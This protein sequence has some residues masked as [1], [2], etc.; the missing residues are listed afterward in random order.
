MR[1]R[2]IYSL[3]L[4]ILLSINISGCSTSRN[5]TPPLDIRESA[6]V[7]LRDPF[8]AAWTQSVRAIGESFFVMNN[9]IKDSKVINL[10]YSGDPEK[11]VNCGHLAIDV[12]EGIGTT[13]YQFPAARKSVQFPLARGF[14]TSVVDRQMYLEARINIL[15]EELDKNETG[16]KVVVQYMVTRTGTETVTDRINNRTLAIPLPPLTFSFNTGG[17]DSGTS[18][19]NLTCRATGE[20]EKA[21]IDLL[22][23]SYTQ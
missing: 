22:V 18:K 17:T 11:Y 6:T 7:I 9:V 8:E 16:V 5:Y 1:K 19:T 23:S 13:S 21:L 3:T 10:S 15:F 2:S 14:R 12:K 20:M 4:S